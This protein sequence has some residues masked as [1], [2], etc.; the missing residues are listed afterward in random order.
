[1]DFEKFINRRD[2]NKNYHDVA[3]FENSIAQRIE[4]DSQ[5]SNSGDRLRGLYALDDLDFISP[6]CPIEQITRDPVF[7]KFYSQRVRKSKRMALVFS[8]PLVKAIVDPYDNIRQQRADLKIRSEVVVHVV[9]DSTVLDCLSIKK[10]HQVTEDDTYDG[11]LYY[12]VKIDGTSFYVRKKSYTTA[13]QAV[14]SHKDYLNRIAV[15][16][17]N[18]FVSGMFILEYHNRIQTYNPGRVDP[19]YGYPTDMLDIYDRKTCVESRH[20]NGLFKSIID[21][22]DYAELTAVI[23]KLLPG[24]DTDKI[25]SATKPADQENKSEKDSDVENNTNANVNDEAVNA[26]EL[27]RTQKLEIHRGTEYD[28]ENVMI[29][30]DK[31]KYSVIEYLMLKMMSIDHVVIQ[32]SLRNM[33]MLIISKN[34]EFIR[35]PYLHALSIG[36]NQSFPSLYMLISG[37]EHQI[38]VDDIETID[39]TSMYHIDMSLIKH[40]ITSDDED[41]FVDYITR[42]KLL[43]KL[44]NFESKTGRIIADWLVMYSPS[45]IVATLIETNSL[46]K[47]DVY[48]LIFLTQNFEYLDPKIIDHIRM[49]AN[50]EDESQTVPNKT[51]ESDSVSDSTDDDTDNAD[52]TNNAYTKNNAHVNERSIDAR[53]MGDIENSRIIHQDPISE[54]ANED[55]ADE[56][57]QDEDSANEN[58]PD[59]DSDSTDTNSET[60]TDTAGEEITAAERQ[61]LAKEIAADNSSDDTDDSDD[62]DNEDAET[63]SSVGIHKVMSGLDGIMNPDDVMIVLSVLREIVTLGLTSSFYLIRQLCPHILS[64]DYLSCV[65]EDA[66]FGSIVHWVRTDDS[67]EVLQLMIKYRPDIVHSRDARGLTPLLSIAESYDGTSSIEKVLVTLLSNGADYED[68]DEHGN[69]ILHILGSKG[70]T[71]LVTV[72]LR[73]IPTIINHQNDDMKT[74]IMIAAESGDE[75]MTYALEGAGADLS[76]KDRYGNTFHHYVCQHGICPGLIIEN[77]PNDFGFKPS[78]Y[79]MYC[80]NF[81]YY[82]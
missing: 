23:N 64:D 59:E 82:R 53:N 75:S 58:S 81:Y 62:E 25:D 16:G 14:M 18:I 6:A 26:R 35:P 11:R 76:Y 24:E 36:F 70:D 34:F 65:G 30:E 66:H 32:Q 21:R 60:I 4:H 37:A 51:L 10:S 46:L 43:K 68:T 56:H 79:A 47:I 22:V 54:T 29:M 13:S 9:S 48:R 17:S 73:M 57:G 50:T 80:Q 27:S 20:Q 44:S 71:K 67:D 55:S 78:D 5:S 49:T 63:E 42:I 15:I 2:I 77:A 45:R 8:G 38:R 28:I 41:M 72:L 33:F 74:P 52:H 61:K 7:Q 19:I 1:M 3:K 12:C 69:T 40:F 31:Q 39:L